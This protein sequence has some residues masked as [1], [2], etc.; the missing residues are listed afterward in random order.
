[1]FGLNVN[2]FGSFIFLFFLL[3]ISGCASGPSITD[4]NINVNDSKKTQVIIYRDNLFGA[5]IQPVI[6]VNGKET[7][8]CITN[9]VFIVNISPGP[10]EIRATTEKENT[11]ITDIKLGETKFIRCEIGMGLIAGRIYFKELDKEFSTN[12]INNLVFTGEY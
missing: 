10:L 6:Y 2:K 11:Y 7:G 4:L 3:F 12:A 5:A 9:G 8:K 1:M